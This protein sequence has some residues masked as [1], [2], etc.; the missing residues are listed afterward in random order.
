MS[1]CFNKDPLITEYTIE[2]EK[3]G[4]GE[5]YTFVCIAD[6][7]ECSF[8]NENEKLFS[9]IDRIKPDG[10]MIPGDLAEASVKAD[11]GET[12]YFLF[13]LRKKYPN[14]F[15][16]P[17]NHE[18]KI[19]ERVKYTRQM[20]VLQ[21]GLERAGVSLM[22]NTSADI[23]AI[24]IYGLDLNHDYYRRVIKREVPDGMIRCLLGNRDRTKFNIMLAHDPD[25]FPEYV[26]WKPDLILSGH[27]HGGLIRIP[28]VGGLISPAY[29]L[30]PRY[31][32]GMYEKDGVKMI[33]SRG[34]GSHTF[35]I[36]INNPPEILKIVISGKREDHL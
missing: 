32:S 33:V 23:N 21:R 31:D 22:R 15:Y 5:K 29:R 30:F 12:M 14:I 10:I 3:L 11:P 6:L 28:K 9:A 17:G 35:N 25:H 16:S 13:K 19:F 20:V 4:N 2:T 36:R 1:F 24:R 7:H 26:K 8:G 18:R 27:V 34:A